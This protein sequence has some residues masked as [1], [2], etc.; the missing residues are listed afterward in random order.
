MSRSSFEV[1]KTNADEA[2]TVSLAHI[3][4]CDDDPEL[5]LLLATLL[6]DH[7]FK[8]TLAADGRE[9]Q[10]QVRANPDVDL[11]I[12]DVMLP[13]TSGLELCRDLRSASNVAIMMLTARGDE[14]D[15]IVGLE[16]GADD[17]MS[18]PFSPNELLAR[19]KALLRRSRMSSDT[20]HRGR[21]R[22]FAFEGWRLDAA[23]RELRNPNGVIID[24]SAGEY[25]LL[26]AFLEAPQR[27]L[28][29]EQLLETARN[30]PAQAFD[31]SIDIQVSRLRRKLGSADDNDGLIKTVRG[32]GYMFVPAVTLR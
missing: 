16:M 30:R 20:H 7:D 12:L 18:K 19:V 27:V 3:M 24:L 29:R 4:I 31:R 1:G 15:R 2:T 9:L 13:G 32:A 25:D 11:V 8:V 6:G 22:S 5:R 26:I 21:N 28:S 14:T 17:Y 23:R 10:R